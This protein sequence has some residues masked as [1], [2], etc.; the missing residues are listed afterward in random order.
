M[1]FIGID[2]AWSGRNSTGVAVLS[3]YKKQAELLSYKIVN[4]ND[5]ILTHVTEKIGN[6]NAHIAIDAPLIV[7]NE[8][9]RRIAEVEVGKLFRKYDAGAHPANRQRFSQW[10]GQV[11][12]EEIVKLFEKAGFKH[13]PYIKKYEQSRKLFEVYP[14]PS[15]VVLFKL[16]KIL[17]YKAKPKR[18]YKFRWKE[19]KKYQNH[20]KNLE[21]LVLPDEIIKKNVGKL[22][23]GKLKN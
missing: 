16:N 10:S 8:T 20:L 22:K 11:R 2:L 19:F 6:K 21:S 15:M 12:G 18:D 7:P 17:R 3:G 5:E 23:G 13:D 14:H 9:G 1:L 4:S